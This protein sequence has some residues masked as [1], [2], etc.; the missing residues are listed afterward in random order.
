MAFSKEKGGAI[1]LP[2]HLARH[3]SA[4]MGRQD[5]NRA[6][7]IAPVAARETRVA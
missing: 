7:V 3:E 1:E 6:A 4:F 2:V 5:W